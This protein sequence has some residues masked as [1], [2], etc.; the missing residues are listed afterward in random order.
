LQSERTIIHLADG[1]DP[2]ARE[3]SLSRGSKLP[4]LG[5]RRMSASSLVRPSTGGPS[6]SL[7][8]RLGS[9]RLYSGVGLS[10]GVRCAAMASAASAYTQ[11][12]CNYDSTRIR[13]QVFVFTIPTRVHERTLKVRS[14]STQQCTHCTANL[15]PIRDLYTGVQVRCIMYGLPVGM[16]LASSRTRTTVIGGIGGEVT[17]SGSRARVSPV[18]VPVPVPVPAGG[19]CRVGKEMLLPSV[20]SGLPPLRLGPREIRARTAG[21]PRPRVTDMAY[22]IAPPGCQFAEMACHGPVGRSRRPILPS[23]DRGRRAS[24]ATHLD[25]PKACSAVE[26]DRSRTMGIG[27][28]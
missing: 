18:P 19:F 1:S 20:G 13:C 15:H 11:V 7:T 16:E 25:S 6:T 21:R 12:V 4:P 5:H 10:G 23:Y 28:C 8:G 24:S 14:S 9:G 17:D 2:A 22:I 3:S 26:N 27:E